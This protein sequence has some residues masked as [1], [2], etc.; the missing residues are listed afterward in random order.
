MPNT[1]ASPTNINLNANGPAANPL[2]A[3][4]PWLHHIGCI[5]TSRADAGIYR[6]LLRQLAAQNTWRV[7]CWAGG[8]HLATEFG[9]T[10]DA[11]NGLDRVQVVPVEHWVPGDRPE[12]VA[13]S[14]GRAVASFAEALTQ[15]RPD[16]LFV[17]GDRTEMLAAALAATILRLPLAHLH[18]GDTT[19]GAY[20]DACRHAIT[21]L[22]HLH[23]PALPEHAENIHRM[24]EEPWRIHPVGA[25]AVDELHLFTPE[26]AADLNAATGLD[27]SRPTFVVAFY[28]E[29]LSPL[30]P[31]QQ[32]EE[33]CAALARFEAQLLI[34]GPNAD[35]GYA[36]VDQTLASLTSKRSSAIRAPAM[37]QHR[38]WSCLAHAGL[39]VGNSSAGLLEAA[40]LRLPVV[41]IGDRQRGRVAPANVWHAELQAENIAAAIRKALHPTFREGLR[42]LRNPYGDGHA[43]ERII[44]VLGRLPEQ[45]EVLI[46]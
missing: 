27:W 33:L 32:A 16:L 23:F 2:P 8:T 24:G 34:L 17:L 35:V 13:A 25:L 6:P 31:R 41:N 10:I 46:K 15:H 45:N 18:G 29:T 20:D 30:S 7:S 12:Q 38:F 44:E 3:R 37:T 28:P 22:S 39:L 14:A 26:T 21:K 43:A 1:P 42:D 11:F 9:R 40:S 36:E 5:S 19:A 4:A